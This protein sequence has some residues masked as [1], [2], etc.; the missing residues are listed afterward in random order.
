[1]NIDLSSLV[2]IWLLTLC[3]AVPTEQNYNLTTTN[4]RLMTQEESTSTLDPLW[5]DVTT[6]MHREDSPQTFMPSTQTEEAAYISISPQL[7]NWTMAE[8]STEGQQADVS[9]QPSTLATEATPMEMSS[10]PSKGATATPHFTDGASIPTTHQTG[11][12]HLISTPTTPKQS[13]EKADVQ[14]TGPSETTSTTTKKTLDVTAPG[15]KQ[16]FPEKKAREESNHGTVVAWIIVGALVLMI[17]SFLIIYVKKNKLNEQQMTTKNWAGPSPF[18][19]NGED[20]G[21]VRLRSTSRISLSSFLP[22]RLS[23]RLSLLPEA[24]E[25]MEDINPGTTFG[26]RR[27]EGSS[28]QQVTAGVVQRSTGATV[29]APEAKT[30]DDVAKTNSVHAASSQTNVPTTP[31]DLEAVSLTEDFPANGVR[32]AAQ[33]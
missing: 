2:I 8:N 30:T 12:T 14:P 16:L 20:N 22:Q 21:Q 32:D 15:K 33:S 4:D 26:D 23:R 27:Q 7:S 19:E 29:G 25:E 17:I 6:N 31:D 28:A 5:P 10:T 11:T 1:M 3:G 24:D 9:V 18:I 13:T